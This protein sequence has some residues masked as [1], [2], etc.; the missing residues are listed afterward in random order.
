MPTKVSTLYDR[1]L[2]DQPHW[3]SGGVLP[4]S[5]IILFGGEAKIMKTWLALDMAHSLTTGGALWNLEYGAEEPVGVHYFDSEVGEYEFHRRVK[6]KYETLGVRPEDNFFFSSKLP[7]FAI[8]TSKGQKVLAREIEESKARVVIIDPIGASMAGDENSN[9]D[10]EK[11]FTN[12][13]ELMISNPELSFVLI[14]HYGKPPKIRDDYDPLSPYNFRG[15]SKFVDRATTLITA[16]AMADHP[17]EWRRLKTRMTI[18]QGPPPEHDIKLSVL[19]GG[20]VIPTP[21]GAKVPG[22]L[23]PG[24]KTAGGWRF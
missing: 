9:T 18:R 24:K 4:K 11:V 16:M 3:I 19:P 2:P 6:V 22:A 20:M 21:E 13:S 23:K 5:G 7:D 1:P 10:V 17:G 12:L 8:D 15:A 14:H